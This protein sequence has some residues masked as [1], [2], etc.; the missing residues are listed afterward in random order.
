VPVRIRPEAP[1]LI[2]ME[3]PFALADVVTH[4]FHFQHRHSIVTSSQLFDAGGAIQ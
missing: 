4:Y 1:N 2:S 3:Q